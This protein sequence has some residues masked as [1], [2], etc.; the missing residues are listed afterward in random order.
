LH[1]IEL[2]SHECEDPRLEQ[3]LLELDKHPALFQTL[4]LNTL[5]VN[6]LELLQ[7]GVLEDLL[8]LGVNQAVEILARCFL[9]SL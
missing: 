6:V 4:G 7:V 3:E 9:K 2:L 1:L 5:I 8:N